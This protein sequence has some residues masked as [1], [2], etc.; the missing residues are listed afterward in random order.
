MNNLINF[1]DFINES[2]NG[3][4]LYHS[5]N[6]R[7]FISIVTDDLMLKSPYYHNIS[8]SRN[9]SFWHNMNTLNVRLVF[10]KN[11]LAQKY[12]I[13][14]YDYWADI[15]GD[16]ANVFSK[17]N[18]DRGIQFE[19]EETINSDIMNVGKYITEIQIIDNSTEEDNIFLTLEDNKVFLSNYLKK[20]PHIKIYLVEIV[21]LLDKTSKNMC[22]IVSKKE[23]EFTI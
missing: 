20:Y 2:I 10:D 3:N 18:I 19:Y 8:F 6:L 15:K 22:R 12:K 16:T 7:K 11:L 5:T 23:L 9:K 4:L 21:P 17:S 13:K 14:P 1:N